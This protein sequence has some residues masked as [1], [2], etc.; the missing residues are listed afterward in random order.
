MYVTVYEEIYATKCEKKTKSMRPIRGKECTSIGARAAKAEE[1]F[2]MPNSPEM[3]TSRRGS[4]II[5]TL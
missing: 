4:D 3:A 5:S 1:K 2:S